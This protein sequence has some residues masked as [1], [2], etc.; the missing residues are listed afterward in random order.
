[1]GSNAARL[2]EL[3]AT[4][5]RKKALP[6]WVGPFPIQRRLSENVYAVSF[7]SGIRV[8]KHVNVKDIKV[9]T[10]LDDCPPPL[11]VS[12]DNTLWAVESIVDAHKTKGET[13]VTLVR[14]TGFNDPK[15]NTWEPLEKWA[16][17]LCSSAHIL[18][19]TKPRTNS[20]EWTAVARPYQLS[21]NE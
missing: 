19:R 6:K 14:W 7:P 5:T 8:S 12:A 2:A 17:Y 3:R 15:D 13:Y 20:G 1:M 10:G 21:R 18:A 16:T 9:A 11:H 4:T